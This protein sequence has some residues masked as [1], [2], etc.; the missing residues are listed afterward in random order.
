MAKEKFN[1]KALFVN[2][3][4]AS[5]VKP[6]E[7]TPAKTTSFPEERNTVTKFPE[8]VSM[9]NTVNVDNSVLGTVIEMYEAGFE[10]LNQPGYDFYEFFKAIKAVGSND[11]SVYKMAFT[12]AQGVDAAVNK[13]TLLKQSDFYVKEINKVHQ[14][15]RTKGTAKKAQIQDGLKSKKETLS[16]EIS[17]LE[18]QIL[19]LQTQI[20]DKKSQL[21]SV[22]SNLI[23]DVSDIEQKIVANDLAK[24]KILETINS[25]IDGIKNNL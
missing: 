4:G 10:S 11:P 9:A 25:V 14:Q 5:G 6:K 2:D 21:Q 7:N 3:E 12:M 8:K 23:K 15:Y 20:G 16:S 1:W 17:Q 18:K 19:Q 24:S 22:D 13:P